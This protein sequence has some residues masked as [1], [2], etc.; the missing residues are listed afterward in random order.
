M[1]VINTIQPGQPNKFIPI[2]G[3]VLHDFNTKVAHVQLV[4]TQEYREVLL[5]NGEVQSSGLD[6]EFYHTKLVGSAVR[7]LEKTVIIFGGG[8]GCT[9]RQ[10]LN[11]AADASITQY[12]YDLQTMIWSS[13]ALKHWNMDVYND[14]RLKVVIADADITVLEP[15]S[16][17][18]III[19]LF[20][21]RPEEESF[22][23]RMICKSVSALRPGCRLSAYLG[24]DTPMLRSFLGRLQMQIG[25]ICV[26]RETFAYIPS[27]GEANSVF[28][29]IEKAAV[30]LPAQ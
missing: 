4:Y 13:V 30:A 10:V 21:Y 11:I 15:N 20:D 8:E 29:M 9:A 25:D 7:G 5:M 22:M 14:P 27:Y 18:A 1:Q 23:V 3:R 17:D 6:Q 28:L 16:I 24:D 26:L 12:D 2:I 19:D